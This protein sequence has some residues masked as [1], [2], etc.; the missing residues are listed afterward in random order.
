[1]SD[2]AVGSLS[3]GG[4]TSIHENIAVLLGAVGPF[5]HR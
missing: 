5:V 4:A 2:L 1:M 3:A